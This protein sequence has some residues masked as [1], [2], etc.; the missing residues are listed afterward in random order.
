M[1]G[2]DPQAAYELKQMMREHAAKGNCVLFSTHVLEVAEKL[3]DH[4]MIIDHG[5]SLYQGTVEDLS[6]AH[7]G[8]DLEE[9]FLDMIDY[10][11]SSQ[12]DNA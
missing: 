5:R 3:C 1:T 7:P 2:L 12:E 9:I 10:K 4:I 6:A 11:G 8:K